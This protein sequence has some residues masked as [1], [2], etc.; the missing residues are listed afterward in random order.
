MKK[1]NKA[2]LIGPSGIGLAHLREFKKYGIKSI[3]IL[4]KN[5]IKNKEHSDLFF[6][7]KKIKYLR[8][9][10]EIK[11]FKPDII[12]LCTPHHNHIQ[13]L[14]LIK[15]RYKGPIIVEKPFIVNKN[16]NYNQHKKLSDLFYKNFKNIYVNLPMIFIVSQLKRYIKQKQIKN[17]DFNYNTRGKHQYEEI[18]ID[19]LPHA[20]SFVLT[21][22]NQELKNFKLSKLTINR[23]ISKIYIKINNVNCYFNFKQNEKSKNS[24]LSFNIN[25]K[26]FKR[27]IV[28]KD[29]IDDVYFQINKKNIKILN[30]MSKSLNISLKQL[31]KQINNKKNKSITE[32]ITKV[33]CYILENANKE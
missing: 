19:L 6:E 9:F 27:F 13:H 16:F 12:S 24:G 22:I 28:K 30:P 18:V 31:N 26:K 2:L 10:Q 4:R 5:F 29:K 17:I 21:C 14:K 11:K 23:K 8:T 32:S 1:F 7:K 15:D 3:G 33:T 25:K 20:L